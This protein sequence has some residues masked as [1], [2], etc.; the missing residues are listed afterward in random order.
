MEKKTFTT[1]FALSHK[2]AVAAIRSTYTVHYTM[3]G[4]ET[5]KSDDFHRRYSDLLLEL[6]TLPIGTVVDVTTHYS[7]VGTGLT[8]F[9]FRDGKGQLQKMSLYREETSL[10]KEIAYTFLHARN[11]SRFKA[12]WNQRL[13]QFWYS[14]EPLKEVA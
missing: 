4:D 8:S 13:G 3:T 12:E 11:F 6:L 5:S 2:Q 9:E 7:T 10:P 14:A 1:A